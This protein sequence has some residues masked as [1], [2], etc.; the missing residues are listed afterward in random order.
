MANEK[1]VTKISKTAK[2]VSIRHPAHSNETI[3]GKSDKVI[4]A[5]IR[6]PT[7]T[8]K[9]SERNIPISPC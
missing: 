7:T 1:M 5:Q 3:P 9:T 6:K 8:K 2:E 4:A